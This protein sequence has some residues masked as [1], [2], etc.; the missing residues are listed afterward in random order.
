MNIAALIFLIIG[1]ASHF[2]EYPNSTLV[3]GISLGIASI[4]LVVDIIQSLRR[5]K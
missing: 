1:W 3:S 5:K 4:L 2:V